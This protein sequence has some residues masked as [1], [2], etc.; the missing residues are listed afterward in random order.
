MT[1]K[2]LKRGDCIG[3]AAPSS[4]FDRRVFMKGVHAL[5]RL[6]FKPKF[7]DDIFDQNRY[8]AGTDN[9][10]AEEL[11]ELFLDRSVAAIMFARGG[12]GSQ[13]V[14]PL[15]DKALIAEHKKPVVG[16]SDITALLTFLRQGAGVPT[17]YG[18]VITQLG[19]AKNDFTE[20]AL[21][22]ALTKSGAMG[23]VACQ[24]SKVL[25]EGSA[26]GSLVGGCLTLINSS[27]GTS[28]E[29][30]TSGSILL[31]EDIGEKVYALDRMLT[32]LKNSGKLSSAVGIIFG[33]LIPPA[34]EPHNVEAMIKDVLSDF[35]GP[36]VAGFAAG[37]LDEFITMPL[38]ASLS[39]SSSGGKAKLEFT[40]GILK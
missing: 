19:N 25:A 5:E 30:D 17:F 38:G 11:T 16:F 10:R 40:S 3:I 4:P 36:V 2:A 18:P 8:L 7:R 21:F 24:T 9:R 14:I 12:Y 31:I 34:D 35:S 32:Q 33:S 39:I 13:R 29:L 20:N 6:G 26:E 22:S 23:E 27:M 15:L 37:H 1:T 28:Y